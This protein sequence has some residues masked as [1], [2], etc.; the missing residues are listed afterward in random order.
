MLYMLGAKTLICFSNRYIITC[1]R[2]TFILYVRLQIFWDFILCNA[3][4]TLHFRA[5]N[6][7]NL[8][9]LSRCL[10]RFQTRFLIFVSLC[11]PAQGVLQKV[12]AMLMFKCI[13]VTCIF[14]VYQTFDNFILDI[15]RITIPRTRFFNVCYLFVEYINVVTYLHFM[16]CVIKYP[17]PCSFCV[18]WFIAVVIYVYKSLLISLTLFI[19]F[20][21]QEAY[22]FIFNFFS[23]NP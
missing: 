17:K 12:V 5:T 7:S 10:L 14:P 18:S 1:W 21:I 3:T 8:N 15:V 20:F 6:T 19:F 4:I 11:T 2:A 23:S 22:I 9:I 16:S 13:T